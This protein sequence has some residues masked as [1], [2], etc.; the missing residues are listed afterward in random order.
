MSKAA[1]VW[2]SKGK[3][4][5][6]PLDTAGRETLPL[7]GNVSERGPDPP[8]SFPPH[9]CPV[10]VVSPYVLPAMRVAPLRNG[11]PAA[12]VRY[13]PRVTRRVVFFGPEILELHVDFELLV[14]LPEI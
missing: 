13:Q 9:T 3:I 7:Q 10:I 6:F 2:L 8:L 1:S 14:L 11:C 4:E 5:G 12:I